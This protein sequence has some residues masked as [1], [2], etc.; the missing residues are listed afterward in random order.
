VGDG[1]EVLRDLVAGH[2]DAGV[3]NRQGPGLLVGGD[4]DLGRELAPTE[5]LLDQRLEASLVERVGG[6]RNQLTQEDLGVRVER[7][8]DEFE[9]GGDFGLE[10]VGFAAHGGARGAAT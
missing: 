2:P 1:A 4:Q 5:V 7:V 3:R 8:G 6:V 9:E 10:L